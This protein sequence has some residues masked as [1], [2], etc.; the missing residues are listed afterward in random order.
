MENKRINFESTGM[1]WNIEA[2][3]NRLYISEIM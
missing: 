1:V 3:D 2:R